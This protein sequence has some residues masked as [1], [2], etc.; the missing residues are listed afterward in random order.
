ML[1]VRLLPQVIISGKPTQTDPLLNAAHAAWAPDK[2]LILI[3]PT[4]PDSLGFWKAHNPE[5]WA[6]VE[7]H[8]S[9]QQK[10][11]PGSSSG[12]AA[13]VAEPPAGAAEV[14]VADMG[15]Q[16]TES[17]AAAAAGDAGRSKFPPT[18]FVCQNFTCQAPTGDAG[19]VYDLLTLQSTGVV[20]LQPVKL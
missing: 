5:A 3:D 16:P 1:P 8:Y 15:L 2:A 20:K 4:N 12:G 6:M 19:K 17:A 10:H 13:T 9:K 14:V 11:A 18:A 7:A